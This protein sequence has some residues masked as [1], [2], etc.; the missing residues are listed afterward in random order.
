[1]CVCVYVCGTYAYTNIFIYA[2]TSI[3]SYVQM[4]TLIL[5]LLISMIE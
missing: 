3:H 1:M 2:T 4:H 5:K